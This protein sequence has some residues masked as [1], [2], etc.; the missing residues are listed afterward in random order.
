MTCLLSMDV[1]QVIRTV[2][3]PISINNAFN[4]Q[5]MIL[6][7]TTSVSLMLLIS[8]ILCTYRRFRTNSS[9][10]VDVDLFDSDNDFK[11][12]VSSNLKETLLSRQENRYP[13]GRQD[14]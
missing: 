11:R 5:S 12:N 4:G 10:G 9:L 14:I 6:F 3:I 2:N 1:I 7:C 13:R 8:G